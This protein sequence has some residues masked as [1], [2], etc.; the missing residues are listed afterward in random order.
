MKLNLSMQRAAGVE[1]AP[2]LPL[3]A[4]PRLAAYRL[5]ASE[6]TLSVPIL[7]AQAIL[8]AFWPVPEASKEAPSGR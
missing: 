8:R 6:R 2:P 4:T 7:P 5:L 3:S 1:A